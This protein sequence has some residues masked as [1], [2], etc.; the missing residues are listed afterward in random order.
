MARIVVIGGGVGGL[1]SAMLLARDGH[2]VTVLERDPTVPPDNADAAWNN[3]ERRGVNQFRM[4]HLFAPRFH[5]LLRAELPDVIDEVEALGA[6]RFNPMLLVP[7]ETSGGYRESDAEFTMVS[8]RR[9]VMETALARAGARTD[10][11]EVRRG[12]AGA[13]LLTDGEAPNGVP[14]VVGVR[15]DTGEELRADLVVDAAGRRSA[16]PAMLGAVGARAPDEE[17][18]DSGFMYYGRH[19]RSADGQIP[20]LM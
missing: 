15:L 2:E 20:P 19:F 13:G 16:L 12:A 1:T 8:A 14:N 11:L 3:W 9:P 10:R 4:I 7:E 18:E 17:L 6:I 5:A